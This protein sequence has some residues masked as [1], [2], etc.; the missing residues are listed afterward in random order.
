MA[1]NNL[2]EV[3]TYNEL[4]EK[5]KI[6]GVTPK[7]AYSLAFK[8]RFNFDKRHFWTMYKITTYLRER[9]YY[10]VDLKS[11]YNVEVEYPKK[12][13]KLYYKE[14]KEEKWH[15]EKILGG[16]APNLKKMANYGFLKSLWYV[17][18]AYW[19]DLI[20][21]VL[22]N[23]EIIKLIKTKMP[24][25][26]ASCRKVIEW[27]ERDYGDVWFPE[28]KMDKYLEAINLHKLVTEKRHRRYKFSPNYLDIRKA[29]NFNK[30]KW[31]SEFWKKHRHDETVKKLHKESLDNLK[32][33]RKTL[34]DYAKST[35][36]LEDPKIDEGRYYELKMWFLKHDWY[37]GKVNQFKHYTQ[38]NINLIR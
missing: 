15:N 20:N 31:E 9:L 1:E 19:S 29:P 16:Y 10:A 4:I 13:W 36:K 35:Y 12:L 27:L 22:E 24:K 5:L 30:I 28:K 38:R 3:K 25:R 8:S 23:K 7:E 18:P 26:I 17:D 14:L 2:L 34:P 21:A 32:H 37:E 33:W 11:K 6:L